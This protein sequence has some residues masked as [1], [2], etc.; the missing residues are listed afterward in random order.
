MNCYKSYKQISLMC[1]TVDIWKTLRGSLESLGALQW[2]MVGIVRSGEV[3]KVSL[4]VSRCRQALARFLARG[5]VF[6][7]LGFGF[8]GS[9]WAACAY[10]EHTHSRRTDHP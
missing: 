6:G 10:D 5:G 7:S 4:G 2:P 3:V 9:T 8:C 1:S